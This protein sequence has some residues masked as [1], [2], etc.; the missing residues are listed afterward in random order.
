MKHGDP[1]HER[2]AEACAT[3]P[4]SARSGW[5]HAIEP[6]EDARLTLGWD[7]WSL[8]ADDKGVPGTDGVQVHP[9]EGSGR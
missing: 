7:P 5:I 4:A 8:I 3:V 6:L 9:H 1:S 2:E